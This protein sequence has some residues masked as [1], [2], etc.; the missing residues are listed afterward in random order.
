MAATQSRLDDEPLRGALDERARR[1][2]ESG[3]SLHTVGVRL[4]AF[5]EPRGAFQHRPASEL[6][7]RADV[8]RRQRH[9]PRPT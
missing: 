3:L 7:P 5:M 2:A 9:F 8:E 1:R 4:R 6:G